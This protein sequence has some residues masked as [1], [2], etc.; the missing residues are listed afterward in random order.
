MDSSV[1]NKVY[2]RGWGRNDCYQLIPV[3]D[4][5]TGNVIEG[6]WDNDTFPEVMLDTINPG[7]NLEWNEQEYGGSDDLQITPIGDGEFLVQSTG[8]AMLRITRPGGRGQRRDC[9]LV[10]ARFAFVATPIGE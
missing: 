4:D 7:W 6:D 1:H 9:G 5:V 8:Q 2:R 10:D 3:E